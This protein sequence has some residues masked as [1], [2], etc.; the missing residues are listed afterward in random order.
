MTLDASFFKEEIRCDFLVTEKR[1][2]IWAVELR[3]LEKL[4][5]VCKKHQIRYFVYYGTL[6][7][8]V[9][10]QGFV[11]W[12]D[13]LDVAMFRDDYER[14][15]AVAPQEFK[16][17]YFFQ[18]AYT[19]G[20]IRLMSKIRDS[21]TTAI[22]HLAPSLNQGIFIDIFPLDAAPD[23]RND[24]LETI[25]KAQKEIWTSI[26]NP[27]EILTNLERGETYILAA[28][29]LVDLIKLEKRERFKQFEA[30]NL[31]QFEESEN[32][33][34]LI[35]QLFSDGAQSAKKEW[36]QETVYLPFENLLV[37][38]PAGYDQILTMLY[39]DYHQFVQG[40]S[41]HESVIMD[42]DIPY[43]EYFEK[44]ILKKEHKDSPEIE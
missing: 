1:K 38:A 19:D 29:V 22:E 36:F 14:F 16:E 17:P 4:D 20:I 27:G 5:E 40:G 35:R 26:V 13:D 42:P 33:D 18:N 39:G 25:Q 37:P 24:Q 11:P 12:D 6:L 15:Q 34:F 30:F 3:L 7:G 32:V 10:H 21:R 41:T 9:R 31:S 44:Y 43:G 28:D 2:K 23:G 8:A